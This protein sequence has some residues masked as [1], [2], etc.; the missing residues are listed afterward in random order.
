[1]V[2]FLWVE[3]GSKKINYRNFLRRE[4]TKNPEKKPLII[5]GIR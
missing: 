4:N 3:R 2:H 5:E 1:L